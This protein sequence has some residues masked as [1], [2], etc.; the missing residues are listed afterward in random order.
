MRLSCPTPPRTYARRLQPRRS[1]PCCRSPSR[2]TSLGRAFCCSASVE[3]LPCSPR[4]PPRRDLSRVS[5]SIPYKK[6]MGCLPGVGNQSFLRGPPPLKC[7]C[8]DQPVAA[9]M[10]WRNGRPLQVSIFFLRCGHKFINSSTCTNIST[11][12]NAGGSRTLHN[13]LR[14]AQVQRDLDAHKLFLVKSRTPSAK[15]YR[16]TELR[17]CPATIPD[18]VW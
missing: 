14:R 1:T 17:C 12:S 6:L 4:S 7:G 18:I 5:Y 3:T 16:P 10:W 11:V 8:I 9:A 13:V 15:I 2:G